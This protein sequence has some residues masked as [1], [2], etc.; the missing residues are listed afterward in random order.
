MFIEEDDDDDDI[1]DMCDDDVIGYEVEEE[2]NDNEQLPPA[3]LIPCVSWR[4]SFSQ[5]MS[6]KRTAEDAPPS[7]PLSK[8]QRLDYEPF[9]W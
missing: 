1:D 3:P 9:E 7:S 8:R 2:C 6:T 4:G 5:H